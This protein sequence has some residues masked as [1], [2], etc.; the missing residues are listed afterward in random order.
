MTDD[1]WSFHTRHTLERYD[2]ALLRQVA[3]KLC[4]PRNQWPVDEILDRVVAALAN[5]AMVDRRLKELPPECRRLL[6]VIGRSRQVRW[7]VG[8]LVEI[9]VAL[10]APDGLEPIVTLLESGLL[11]P[12]LYPLGTN[13]DADKPSGRSK[14]RSFG[15]WL[16]RSDP[17]PMILAAPVVTRRALGED[18]GIECPTAEPSANAAVHEA[19]GL[20]WPL[21]VA[22]LWQQVL[23]TPI[24]RTQQGGY[25]KRDHER[26][27]A[28]PLLSAAVT[29]TLVQ[30]PDPGFFAAALASA[31]GLLR[32][33]GA[34]LKGNDWPA[35]WK[36]TLPTL[37]VELWTAL[38]RVSSWNPV[39]GHAPI[40]GAGNPYPAA[41]TLA[42]LLLAQLPE[43]SWADPK[44]IESWIGA[45]HPFWKGKKTESLGVVPF[46]LGLAY[47]LRLLHATK[48]DD[49]W[50]VR[51]SPL[52]RWI[53]GLSEK[54]PALPGFKQT[55]L[56]QPNLEFLAYRQGLT[57][58]LIAS[59]SKFATWKTL[60]PACTLLLE[61]ASVYR[62]LEMGESLTSIMQLLEG[63][64]MK[65]IP[66]AVLD[67]L[68]TW[69][70]KR[71][72]LSVYS[73]GAIFEFGSPAEMN[74]AI[75]RGLP[76][77][78]LTDRLGIVANESAI[79]YKHF[80]LTG[81]RD[82]TLPPEKCVDVEPDGVTLSVD[83]ARSDLLLETELQRFAEALP[84]PSLGDGRS[85][86]SMSD[87]SG[88]K[89]AAGRVFYRLT[90]SSLAAARQ[91][92]VTLVYLQKW[93]AQRTGLPISAA[94]QLLMTG[95]EAPPIE[96]R[97][98]LVVHV[99]NEHLADGLQQWPG[100]R[101][102]IVAR[103]GPTALVV[104][105]VAVPVLIE[106]LK[107][108]GVRMT[109]PVEASI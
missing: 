60:G 62:A 19:D 17:M 33:D 80:R 34:E 86:S 63:H 13:P 61:P 58:E 93:F 83:L 94:A 26:L 91:Q 85:S 65:A 70:S 46:L 73:A 43:N 2:E 44:A 38:V 105:E 22:V 48:G 99:A 100:T 101:D 21:R 3:H 77:V 109:P 40:E 104:E 66:T 76:V 79:E 7:P 49:G 106:R 20:E 36:E 45:R 72:R 97:R 27:Q 39:A 9:V 52:A 89:I 64:G 96:M 14:L 35:T 4:K 57:P 50:L 95:P 25:F 12:E 47:S 88:A 15:V 18:L 98:Q 75:A 37:V 102:L 56:V 31:V 41:Y 87:G 54:A 23:A 8:S 103:L 10:G 90:P 1:K 28:D 81:T 107:E 67:S 16:G 74:D 24:R 108:L 59:L 71:E 32:E 42:M 6:A 5:V 30:V 84:A 68:K 53:M 69:S 29:D 82:Y 92:G 11:L 51:L 78:R 55:L